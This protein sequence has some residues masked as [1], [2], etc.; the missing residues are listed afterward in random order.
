MCYPR[1]IVMGK[2]EACEIGKQL[3]A[4]CRVGQRSKLTFFGGVT[5]ALCSFTNERIA[6]TQIGAGRTSLGRTTDVS[7]Y[8]REL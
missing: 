2:D 5:G 8:I 1:G 3:A 6:L 4:Y 7:R